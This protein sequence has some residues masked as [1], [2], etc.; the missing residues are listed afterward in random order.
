MSAAAARLSSLT[1]QEADALPAAELYKIVEAAVLDELGQS[2]NTVSAAVLHSIVREVVLAWP[3]CPARVRT[4]E[5][6]QQRRDAGETLAEFF[7]Q[8]THL[9]SD[10]F[11]RRNEHLL[12]NPP[13]PVSVSQV[14]VAPTSPSSQ[15]TLASPASPTLAS[16]TS[17]P[18]LDSA[19]SPPSSVTLSPVRVADSSIDDTTDIDEDN[20]ET[21]SFTADT[22]F[23]TEPFREA[24]SEAVAPDHLQEALAI[25]R[26]T[27]GSS[28]AS[29]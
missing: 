28:P 19:A 23:E 24:V 13:A 18:T 2:A 6:F 12:V 15:P 11:V 21:E 5:W 17:P 10:D 29:R 3:E 1:A 27:R 7:R 8:N 4:S 25:L 14:P 26:N 22:S 16:P 20:V 9:F